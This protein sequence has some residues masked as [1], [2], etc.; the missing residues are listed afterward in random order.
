MNSFQ[1]ICKKKFPSNWMFVSSAS[2]RFEFKDSLI[3]RG[4]GYLVRVQEEALKYEA[5]IFLEDFAKE[6]SDKALAKI[7]NESNP[8]KRIIDSCENLTTITHIH[9]IQTNL[10]PETNKFNK[11][12]LK[13]IYKK[14]DKKFDNDN[15]SDILISFVLH[16]FS[17]MV[18]SEEEGLTK[19][20]LVTNFERS[21]VNRSLCLAYH[22]YDCAAC[23]ENLQA[24]YGEIAR[25]F[26]H[27]HHLNPISTSG[28]I[29]PD[30]ILDFVPLCPNCHSI[31]HLENPPISIERIKEKIKQNE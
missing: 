16:L 25:N 19:S 28:V 14:N 24:K 13:L 11:W 18:D 2:T 1:I 20:E 17:Y 12:N 22:G 21:H 10:N 31:A 7:I 26:I 23:N 15:F 3:E 4:K 30:P 8:I 6:L 9:Y 27:V 5:D 29:K